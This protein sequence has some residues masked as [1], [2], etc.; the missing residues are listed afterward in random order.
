VGDEPVDFDKR[1]LIEQEVNPFAGSQFAVF[2]LF[3]DPVLAAP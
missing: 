2:V 1:A 3:V